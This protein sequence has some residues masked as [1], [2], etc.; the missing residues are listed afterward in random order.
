MPLHL[1]AR[2]GSLEEAQNI[3]PKKVPE[4][5]S[6]FMDFYYIT[7]SAP[8]T[9]LGTQQILNNAS[10]TAFTQSDLQSPGTWGQGSFNRRMA[11]LN[12]IH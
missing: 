5:G 10:W 1:A 4:N 11:R 8:S 9:R 3:P 2:G 7:H 6:S 12:I